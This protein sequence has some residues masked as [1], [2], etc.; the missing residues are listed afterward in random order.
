M[1][2]YRILTLDGGG[3][4]ALIEVMALIDLYSADTTGHQVLGDFDMVAANSGGSI[5]LGG[6]VEDLSLQT[7]LDFF[8]SQDKRQSIFVRK[9]LHLPSMEKYVTTGKL[10]GLRA[11]F[12]KRCDVPLNKVAQD[13]PGHSG[14]PVHL[15][16]AGFNYDRN[17]GEFFRSAPATRDGFGIGV[18]STATLAE[19]IHAS[20]NAPIRYFDRPAELPTQPGSHYWDGAISGSNNP[21][22]IAVT[23][24]L[25]LGQPGLGLAALSIGTG[26]TFLP[27]A[28]ENAAPEPY[29][30]TVHESCLTTDL[31]KIAGAILDDP[32]DVASFVAH[33]MSGGP[34]AGAVAPVDSSIVR[35]NPMIAPVVNEDDEFVLP[36]GMDAESF[37]NLVKLDMDAVEQDQVDEIVNF[38][39][40]WLKGSISNQPVRAAADLTPVIGQGKYAQ[41]KDAWNKLAAMPF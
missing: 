15:L 30:L 6:L 37:E 23:E 28:P 4:W 18:P 26:G 13:I 17:R 39:R 19:C 10:A 14:K 21:I 31:E 1:E 40:L 2:R 32:P 7:M 35:L 11:A 34:P 38:A 41:G 22:L 8:L 20:S 25:V 29:Y 24:A 16:I 27:M 33:V 3:A 36:H 9:S 5:V 12:P